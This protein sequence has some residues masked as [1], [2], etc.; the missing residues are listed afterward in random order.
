MTG[1]IV[2]GPL[3]VPAR[4]PISGSTNGGDI[5][6]SDLDVRLTYSR[7][8]GDGPLRVS[9]TK[10]THTF[11]AELTATTATLYHDVGGHRTT[12]GA[13]MRLPAGGRPVRVEL[14][15][16]D[17]RATLRI[18]DAVV[19]Q[20]TPD[21]YAPDLDALLQEYRDQT[22]P[23][24]PT[25]TIRADDQQS[26]ISHLSLWRDVYYYNRNVSWA[27]PQSFP[28]KTQQ[29]GDDEYFTMG[30]NSQLSWDARCWYDGVHLPAERLDVQAGRVPGRFLLGKAFYVY[31][32]AGYKAADW[33]PSF[34]PNFQGMR[35]I[36]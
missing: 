4:S 9:L 11:T 17:Y 8:H 29:L 10:R 23:P 34:V 21:Q 13:P 19:A 27:T 18:D 7:S 33:L 15:N 24:L 36:R 16:A 2:E 26:R 35:L 28:T 3:G 31:W 12:I 20:T 6:V 1:Q 5:P 30:D 14:S 32:P 22:V 25:V